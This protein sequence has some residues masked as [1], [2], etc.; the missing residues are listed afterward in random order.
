MINSKMLF[1]R[2]NFSLI[3]KSYYLPNN[4]ENFFKLKCPKGTIAGSYFFMSFFFKN[5]KFIPNANTVVNPTQQILIYHC[6][7]HTNFF[8]KKRFY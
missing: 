8:K 1:D 6:I 4:I 5:L 2:S 7:F 3:S